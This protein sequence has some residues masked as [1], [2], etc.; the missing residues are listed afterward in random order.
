MSRKETSAMNID[1]ELASAFDDIKFIDADADVN[2][3]D[4]E[5]QME[6][7]EPQEAEVDAVTNHRVTRT[8]VW[9]FR[10][11]WRGYGPEHDE[12]VKDEDCNCEGKIAEYMAQVGL[13]TIYC[14]CRVS[15]KNQSGV[16]HVS[17]PAQ[18]RRLVRE[19]RARY[20]N[21]G[22][23]IKVFKITGSAYARMPPKLVQIG[24]A[25][26][27]NDVIMV[28]RA[29]R[30]SRNIILYLSWMEELSERGVRV[31]ATDDNLWY[32]RG[33]DQKDKLDFIQA[34]VNAHKESA[35]L[36][37]RIL[38]SVEERKARGDEAIGGLPYGQMYHRAPDGHLVVVNNQ[39][40]Q[41]VIA[42]IRREQNADGQMAAQLNREG[43]RK[44]G[45]K[46]NAGM[47]KRLR[48]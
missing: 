41:A 30:L 39:Y 47:V 23:R 20:G 14:F 42:R 38:A 26:N 12:W 37:R 2:E 21:T 44:R 24:E 48:Q 4:G 28:Y 43:N 22:V 1:E 27:A 31:F 34:V 40:E 7:M 10:I 6:D 25:A 16:G 8:G 18:A 46:W 32:H 11:R 17:L 36:S 15:S 5:E 13:N 9:S 45:R 19:A 33:L 3:Q 35:V 29:D